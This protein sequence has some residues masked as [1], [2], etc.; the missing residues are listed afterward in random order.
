MVLFPPLGSSLGVSTA[1]LCR[2]MLVCPL[3]RPEGVRGME[4][5]L[6]VTSAHVV[7][8]ELQAGRT[9][10]RLE[11]QSLVTAELEPES[12]TQREPVAEVSGGAGGLVLDGGAGG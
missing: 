9:L 2:P 12:P 4:C 7:E 5:F 11:L 6:Q 3:Q 8:V 1:E 10:G